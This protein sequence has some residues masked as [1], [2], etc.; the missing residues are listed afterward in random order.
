M[1]RLR[2]FLQRELGRDDLLLRVAL[3]LAGL[4]WRPTALTK[5]RF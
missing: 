2:A 4:T 3:L 5:L 1:K